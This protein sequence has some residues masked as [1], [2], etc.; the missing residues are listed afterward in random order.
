MILPNEGALRYAQTLRTELHL[1]E[2]RLYKEGLV[3]DYTTTLAALDAVE[4]DFDGYAAQVVTW[5]AARL[6]TGGG[7]AFSGCVQFDSG[8]PYGVP[9]SI[10]GW[11]LVDVTGTDVVVAIQP[12]DTPIPMGDAGQSLPVEVSIPVT[13]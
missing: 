2:V 4:A 8:S 13:G 6:L 7:A 3:P 10:G 5:N 1:A 12:F 9:N 11:Y